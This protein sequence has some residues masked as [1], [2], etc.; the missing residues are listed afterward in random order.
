MCL[1]PDA[2]PNA[3]P[4]LSK[5]FNE[6]EPDVSNGRILID[7]VNWDVI[8][9]QHGSR[10]P[11]ACRQK[12]YDSLAPS[13]VSRGELPCSCWQCSF[14]RSGCTRVGSWQ[15]VLCLAAPMK[16]KIVM[17]LKVVSRKACWFS[18]MQSVHQANCHFHDAH[19]GDWGI[20]DDRRLLKALFRSSCSTEWQVDWSAVVPQ[21]TAVAAKRRWRLML[22]SVPDAQEKE[23]PAI[24]D[25]LVSRYVPALKQRAGQAA[26]GG[27]QGEREGG[28]PARMNA[29]QGA[30]QEAAA[31]PQGNAAE[32]AR[33]NAQQ[34]E[35][36]EQEEPSEEAT[37]LLD[38]SMRI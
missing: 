25:E 1:R 36:Y 23:F 18:N 14:L 21:R 13:M 27:L 15:H 37:S 4:H 17:L 5:V 33:A 31:G 19:S 16:S 35:A 30:E 8:S 28:E 32:P 20:G 9:R 38:D 10:A 2:I 11:K 24:V 29:L 22:K 3:A 34:L 7:A 6:Q 12:W 26:P